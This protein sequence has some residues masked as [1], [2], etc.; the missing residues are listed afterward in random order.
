MA[1]MQGDK[2]RGPVS[3][4]TPGRSA[5]ASSP[6]RSECLKSLPQPLESDP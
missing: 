6:R 3:A 4:W 2:K 5:F 1:G